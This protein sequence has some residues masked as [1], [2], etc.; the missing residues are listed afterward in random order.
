MSADGLGILANATA[1]ARMGVTL[2][3]F[4][5]QN[6]FDLFPAEVAARRKAYLE[7]V[8]KTGEMVTFADPRD[9]RELATTINP[10]FDSHGKIVQYAVFAYDLTEYK[11]IEASLRHSEERLKEA[12]RIAHL[13]SWELDLVHD[14][15]YWSDEIFRIFELD[16]A[17]FD[18]TY[19][20]FLEVVHPDDR[21]VVDKAYRRSLETRQDYNIS[22]RLLMPDGRIKYVNEV[23]ETQFD[24]SG[25]ALR[26][27]GTVHDVTELLTAQYAIR[28]SE[29]RFRG[30]MASMDNVVVTMDF[31]GRILYMNAAAADQ[32][33]GLP[34]D[35]IGKNIYDLFPEPVAARQ[36]GSVQKSIRENRG[37]IYEV[38]SNV[39]GKL[40]WFRASIQPI[41]DAGGK[42]TQALINST[43][44]EDQK[45]AQEALRELNLTLEERIRE[46]TAE[47]QDLYDHAPCGYHSLDAEGKIIQVNLTEAN[48]LGYSR[49]EMI[50]QPVTAFLSSDSVEIFKDYFP[51]FQSTGQ[52]NNIELDFIRQ[53]GSILP[54]AISASAVYDAQGQFISSRTM[55]FDIS[56]RRRAQEKI[57]Q[58]A[59]R[60]KLATSA[61]QIGIWDWDLRNDKLIWDDQVY[62]LYGLNAD[63][64]SASYEVWIN[65]L[66]PEDRAF[67]DDL[68]IRT[69]NGE[70]EY[71]S[72]FRTQWPDG[73]IHWIKTKGMVFRDRNGMPMRMAGINYEIT[74]RKLAEQQL[75]FQSSLLDVIEQAVFVVNMDGKFSY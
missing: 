40:R 50:G 38:R 7:Q 68:I 1:L 3:Q 42:V 66:L 9:G 18:S 36:L 75:R 26:S 54:V 65:S 33:N 16:P 13:G 61:A 67:N 46:R 37:L 39:Q 29:E 8:I 72:E 48:W 64:Q 15:L 6:I 22:H 11:K 44:I 12:Q 52:L 10:V 20:V 62:Q 28:E 55:L 17:E 43:D 23:C 56:E 57:A 4:I 27:I 70:T 74:S 34:S 59:E 35:F 24:E 53:D 19:A 2:E 71:D 49:Q 51:I 31:E 73:S 63:Q 41:H 45:I 58:L 30:L 32:L 69:L 5:G 60:L 25:R 47:V 14:R 21:E